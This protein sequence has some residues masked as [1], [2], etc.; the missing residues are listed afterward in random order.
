M[1]S[2]LALEILTARPYAYLDDAPLEE[3][4]TQ[5]VIA[6]RWLDDAG[7]Q[8]L[9]SL[10]PAAIT[11]VREEAC[12]HAETADELHDALLALGFLTAEDVD[13]Q[14]SWAPLMQDLADERRATC[15]QVRASDESAAHPPSRRLW[16]AAERLP[17]LLATFG[18]VVST[19]P[20][21]V[22]EE[23]SRQP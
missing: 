6:R 7:A 8:R 19:P 12:P 18:D 4:R 23:F 2:P 3:R 14:A 22:P 10:D 20:I 16:V 21:I 1:P 9:A 17:L 11:R 13:A 15:L 5:A